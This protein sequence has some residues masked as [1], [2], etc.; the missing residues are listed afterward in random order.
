MSKLCSVH[1]WC[2]HS[3]DECT[4]LHPELL[5]KEIKQQIL[6]NMQGKSSAE[7][8]ERWKKVRCWNCGRTGHTKRLC[9]EEDNP[10]AQAACQKA[11]SRHKERT[12]KNGDSSSTIS[13]PSTVSV[14]SSA[15]AVASTFT[16]AAPASAAFSYSTNET[17]RPSGP[18]ADVSGWKRTPT[19]AE[20]TYLHTIAP[21]IAAVT[22]IPSGARFLFSASSAM[23][24]AKD[25]L[26]HIKH[27]GTQG[28]VEFFNEG[29]SAGHT[30]ATYISGHQEPRAPATSEEPWKKDIMETNKRIDKLSDRLDN[31]D[32]K[33]DQIL[34]AL[35]GQAKS[36]TS[37]SENRK[38]KPGEEAERDAEG[39]K[40][41]DED[42]IESYD[43]NDVLDDVLNDTAKAVLT[44]WVERPQKDIVYYVGTGTRGT[45]S[46][47]PATVTKTKKRDMGRCNMYFTRYT[48][49]STS[50]W[51]A[52]N[53][54]YGTPEDANLIASEL[55]KAYNAANADRK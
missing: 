50:G 30:G 4:T 31:Q 9:P 17:P 3:S 34:G 51:T 11:H 25:V 7:D 36:K 40:E 21:C 24:A 47:T 42:L 41:D 14:N 12:A 20:L 33:L 10:E 45:W 43:K 18:H 16:Q 54:I 2:L 44:N 35:T 32:S 19:T 53:L 29:A 49:N 48:R 23:T 27:E 38:R 5:T 1:G 8:L 22:A 28:T 13:T 52:H 55:H 46:T 15:S 39:M 37:R 6:T 26:T